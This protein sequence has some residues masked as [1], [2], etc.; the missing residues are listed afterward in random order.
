MERRRRCGNCFCAFGLLLF[1]LVFGKYG[2]RGY[3]RIAFLVSFFPPG[4]DLILTVAWI[5]DSAKTTSS[6]GNGDTLSVE[7][8]SNL[9]T[10]KYQA[11]DKSLISNYILK[12][13]VCVFFLWTMGSNVGGTVGVTNFRGRKGILVK[14][15][16]KE[17]G[18]K[19]G[20]FVGRTFRR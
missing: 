16:G 7:A 1:F 19:F 11:V 14:I 4:E 13:Y 9:K 5:S 10:Y 20:I 17:R 2:S 15:N 3:V 6:S 18:L 8:L 12:H